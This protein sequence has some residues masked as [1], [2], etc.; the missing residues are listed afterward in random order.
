MN[1][2]TFKYIEALK[3]KLQS[4][5]DIW[6]PVVGRELIRDC[7]QH[8]DSEYNW[9]PEARGVFEAHEADLD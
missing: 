9:S 7:L 3:A 5:I 2:T 6:T 4:E 8:G 1:K